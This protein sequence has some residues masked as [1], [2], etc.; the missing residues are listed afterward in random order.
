MLLFVDDKVFFRCQVSEQCES[1][2]ENQEPSPKQGYNY[3]TELPRAMEM[4]KNID[5]FRPTGTLADR[6]GGRCGAVWLD[7]FEETTFFDAEGLIY[8]IILISESPEQ[9]PTADHFEG[10]GEYDSHPGSFGYYLVMVLE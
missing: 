2:F 4:D 1:C 5:I 8:E 9:W 7:G 3:S 10:D 6:K